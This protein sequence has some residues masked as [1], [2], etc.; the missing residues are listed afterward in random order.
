MTKQKA[1]VCP[2]FQLK[3]VHIWSCSVNWYW[4]Q[5]LSHSVAFGVD[6]VILLKQCIVGTGISLNAIF[7]YVSKWLN[8]LTHETCLVVEKLYST[9]WRSN[10]HRSWWRI[11]FWVRRYRQSQCRNNTV[12]LKGSCH[13]IMLSVKFCLILI[14]LLYSSFT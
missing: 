6:L 2:H 9:S 13:R 3:N 14:E 12:N 7:N 11:H 5:L 10:S 4:C 1:N 8:T